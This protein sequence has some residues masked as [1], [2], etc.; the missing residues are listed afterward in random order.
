MYIKGISPTY[1]MTTYGLLQEFRS[2]QILMTNSSNSC[3][4]RLVPL[5]QTF[6]QSKE[7]GHYDIIHLLINNPRMFNLG[8]DDLAEK[9]YIP[10]NFLEIKPCGLGSRI[11][12]ME[13]DM[14]NIFDLHGGC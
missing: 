7:P 4:S 10:Q 12:D 6:R 13:A 1:Q 5:W 14:V 3:N 2:E 9:P 8:I 11:R